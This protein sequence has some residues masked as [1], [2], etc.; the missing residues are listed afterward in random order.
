[1]NLYE[2]EIDMK[3]GEKSSI[4]RHK[5]PKKFECSNILVDPECTKNY[6]SDL[7]LSKHHFVQLGITFIVTL[8]AFANGMQY[9]WIGPTLRQ[10]MLNKTN[11]EMDNTGGI[12]W[13]A[14]SI[15]LG[16]IFGPFLGSFLADYC[17]RKTTILLA[18][19]PL[20]IAWIIISVANKVYQLCL[21]ELISG[22]A[23]QIS[24][25]ILPIYIG[26]IASAKIRGTLAIFIPLQFY[27]GFL[28]ENIIVPSIS[29]TYNSAI[30]IFVILLLLSTF[31]W[32]PESPYYYLMKNRPEKAAKSLRTLTQT[33]FVEV[34]LESIQNAIDKQC[35]MNVSTYQLFKDPVNRKAFLI[36][37]GVASIHQFCG[38]MVVLLY[39]QVIFERAGTPINANLGGTILCAVG[40]IVFFV[41]IISVDKWGRRPLIILSAITSAIPLII[42]GLY[43]HLKALNYENIGSFSI[44]PIIALLLFKITYGLG[45][46]PLFYVFACEMFNTSFKAYFIIPE[47]KGKTL[48]EIQ[49]MLRNIK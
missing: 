5:L 26:E 18:A 3:D 19:L 38:L 39:A 13:I 1:M 4:G 47:T 43:F 33:N 40:I 41:S 2:G 32:M 29:E 45:I 15:K 34:R 31:S 11:I 27:L 24:F 8:A 6:T 17:G 7:Y 21:A 20:L 48:E 46:G 30:A 22:V 23:V 42:I 37:M 10:L 28:L 14:S 49:L 9:G 35:S 44:V 25:S 36:V 12:S 16:G